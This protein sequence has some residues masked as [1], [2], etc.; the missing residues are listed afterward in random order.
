M[1]KP[2]STI[3]GFTSLWLDS[4]DPKRR[5]DVELLML[6]RG[7]LRNGSLDEPAFLSGLVGLADLAEMSDEQNP[8]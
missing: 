2:E 8:C 4:C 6:L 3:D 1:A 5:L 7:C